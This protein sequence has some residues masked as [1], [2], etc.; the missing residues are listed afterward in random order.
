MNHS[1]LSQ[2]DRM[3]RQRVPRSGPALLGAAVNHGVIHGSGSRSTRVMYSYGTPSRI[4][5]PGPDENAVRLGRAELPEAAKV[6]AHDQEIARRS[7]PIPDP[8]DRDDIARYIS[9]LSVDD[10]FLN[11]MKKHQ[12]LKQDSPDNNIYNWTLGKHLGHEAAIDTRGGYH[13]LDWPAARRAVHDRAIQ[14]VA[15]PN[16]KVARGDRKNFVM[17]IGSPGSGKSTYGTR[18]TK[19][20]IGGHF[21]EINPDLIREYYPEYQGHNE[22]ATHRESQLLTTGPMLGH[23]YHNNHHILL[24]VPGSDQDQME[25]HLIAARERGYKTHLVYVS[26]DPYKSIGGTWKRFQANAYGANHPNQPPSRFVL[27]S[28]TLG[29]AEKPIATYEGLKKSRLLDTFASIV[30]PDAYH[31]SGEG[32]QVQES[33]HVRKRI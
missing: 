11:V 19:D 28:Y 13:T 21:T 10:L 8:Q 30:P 16:A 24:N 26:R 22:A 18:F 31:K 5:L 2:I 25:N 1:R 3:V 23:A 32:Y 29:I 27:P 6:N 9:Q 15:E 17:L 12:A 33:S 4:V 20:W 14:Q 7:R